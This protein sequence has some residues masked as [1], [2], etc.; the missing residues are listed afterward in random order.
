[1]ECEFPKQNATTKEIK[2]ILQNSKT[3]DD[4][5][6]IIDFALSKDISGIFNTTSPDIITNKQFTKALSAAIKRP[7]VLPVPEYIWSN[8]RRNNA[9][10]RKSFFRK[11][12][13]SRL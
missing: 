6:E 3:I 1:M 10:E 11:V 4:V 5:V 9:H 13:E 7:A 2:E 12:A 8:G